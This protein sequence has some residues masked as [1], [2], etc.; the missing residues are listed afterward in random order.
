M[1]MIPI[2]VECWFDG[3]RMASRCYNTHLYQFLRWFEHTE[4]GSFLG[5]YFNNEAGNNA[6]LTLVNYYND[7]FSVPAVPKEDLSSMLYENSN[8]KTHSWKSV[9]QRIDLSLHSGLKDAFS[10]YQCEM[11]ARFCVDSYLKAATWQSDI[12]IWTICG[13]E[14]GSFQIT[15]ETEWFSGKEL[16]RGELTVFIGLNPWLAHDKSQPNFAR[17]YQ[18]ILF[19]ELEPLVL[20]ESTLD[21]TYRKHMIPLWENDVLPLHIFVEFK[22]SVDQVTVDELWMLENQMIRNGAIQYPKGGLC[23]PHEMVPDIKPEEIYMELPPDNELGDYLEL[24]GL[25]EVRHPIGDNQEEKRT[26]YIC[27]TAIS[28]V[29][30]ILSRSRDFRA[31]FMKTIRAI[32]E[33][34]N[35]NALEILKEKISLIV[36]LHELGHHVFRN[37]ADKRQKSERESLANWFASLLLDPF[38]ADLLEYM[39]Q[40]QPSAYSDP[41]MI[42]TQ[43]KLT[44]EGYGRYCQR[45]AALAWRE[46]DE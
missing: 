29:A 3:K 35:T 41:L 5:F 26:L 20:D 18:P 6:S 17:R 39:T 37:L 4:I 45:L 34:R 8:Q 10:D 33:V 11:L 7:S 1:K 32:A 31:K 19:H 16:Q 22:G 2:R 30:F 43:S 9:L 23:H 12:M 42:P 28:R 13:I 14:W 36:E 25:Y 15:D 46:E 24:L 40:L 44:K 38:D 27:K 21:I